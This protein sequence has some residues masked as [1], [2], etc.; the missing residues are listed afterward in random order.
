MSIQPFSPIEG[1]S[2]QSSEEKFRYFLEEDEDEEWLADDVGDSTSFKDITY[3]SEEMKVL[4][5]LESPPNKER[6]ARPDYHAEH[7]FPQW[8]L[9]NHE[10]QSTECSG[11]GNKISE[12]LQIPFSSRSQEQT[13]ALIHWL[14]S[15]WKTAYTMGYKRCGQ[16]TKVFQFLVYKP[17]QDI[18]V[19]GEKGLTF[20]I[21]ISGEAIVLKEGIGQVAVLGKG[22]SFGE[23]ALT[24]GNDRRS[25]TIRARTKVEVLQLHKG[26]YDHFVKDIQLVERRENLHVLRS[27]K[28]FANWPR[29]KV[30]K[31]CN[32]CSRMT[33]KPDENIYCQGDKPEKIYFVIDGQVDVYKEV[34]VVVRNRW[35]TGMK[36]WDEMAKKRVKPFLA[37]SLFKDDYFGELVQDEK[38]TET[39]T[40]KTRCT[41]LTLDRLEFTH[42]ISGGKTLE[43]LQSGEAEN[44]NDKRI[45]DTMLKQ[46][47]IKGGPSTTAQLNEYVK[48]INVKPKKKKRVSAVD[49]LTAT[50]SSIEN[51]AA[52]SVATIRTDEEDSLKTADSVSLSPVKDKNRRVSAIKNSTNARGKDDEDSPSLR[53]HFD[54]NDSPSHTTDTYAHGINVVRNKSTEFTL[55]SRSSSPPPTAKSMGGAVMAANKIGHMTSARKFEHHLMRA[56]SAVDETALERASPVQKKSSFQDLMEA[57]SNH[58]KEIQLD[59]TANPVDGHLKIMVDEIVTA[60]KKTKYYDQLADV[61]FTAPAIVTNQTRRI[62]VINGC[63]LK[64]GPTAV[65]KNYFT[66][67]TKKKFTSNRNLHKSKKNPTINLKGEADPVMTSIDSVVLRSEKGRKVRSYCSEDI[68]NYVDATTSHSSLPSSSS[69]SSGQTHKSKSRLMEGVASYSEK[70]R[71]PPEREHNPRRDLERQVSRMQEKEKLE[72][73]KSMAPAGLGVASADGGN[74]DDDFFE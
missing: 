2:T 33:F 61:R 29:T 41:L 7:L 26:D 74:E 9:N 21:I 34:Y 55:S 22:H 52:D 32:F 5:K 72:K 67:P 58:Q 23:L 24:E 11:Q 68:N 10:W 18:I 46:L 53:S 51:I 66:E 43:E 47:T 48:A 57:V 37:K 69:V 17:G 25:A 40:A 19:E 56:T 62:N 59:K 70:D 28:L 27:C 65:M 12:I 44:L 30:Q 8:I 42:V 63:S 14:M 35:P 54:D 3:E 1:A 71:I 39:V 4:L 45:L 36:T 13:S 60:R 38:R 16:M 50:L 64:F 15:V 49:S 6:V 31:L 20:Y 73:Q